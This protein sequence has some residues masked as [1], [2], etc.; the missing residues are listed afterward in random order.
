MKMRD[1]KIEGDKNVVVMGKGHKVTVHIYNSKENTA[2]I[3][4]LKL[5]R[6]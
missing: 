6:D 2:M 4:E 3:A 1:M 5:L